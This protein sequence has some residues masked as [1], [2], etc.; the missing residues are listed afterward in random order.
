MATSSLAGT[1]VAVLKPAIVQF[2]DHGQ[3]I[4]SG[5]DA[6]YLRELY[7]Y[8]KGKV[9]EVENS[10]IK[11]CLE[12]KT[13]ATPSH[14]G[15]FR[16]VYDYTDIAHPFYRWCITVLISISLLIVITVNIFRFS[17]VLN[18]VRV[19]MES[20]KMIAAVKIRVDV[21]INM[22]VGRP[23]EVT[24]DDGAGGKTTTGG[25]LSRRR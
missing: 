24:H 7:E 21:G 19:S 18:N 16:F 3:F 15:A 9:N 22:R 11:T 10:E 2:R 23:V 8:E 13:G 5:N 17:V 20:E 1:L 6:D 4:K 12:N 25:N 14:P